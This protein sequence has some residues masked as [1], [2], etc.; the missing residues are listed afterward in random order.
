MSQKPPR[1]L[2]PATPMYPAA[3]P[4]PSILQSPAKQRRNI[5][6]A[7]RACRKR[8][9]KEIRKSARLLLFPGEELPVRLCHSPL[10]LGQLSPSRSSPYHGRRSRT[11]VFNSVTITL[12]VQHVSRNGQTVSAR[13]GKTGAEE[14]HG[15]EK[16]RSWNRT[17]DCSLT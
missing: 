11:A 13:P 14:W 3:L 12:L 6:T 9:T 17:K 16:S 8:R 4:G 2:A 1:P 15:R 7:C 10:T 5:T